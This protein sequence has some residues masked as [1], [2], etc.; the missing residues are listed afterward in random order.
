[1]RPD[2]IH[3][4][5]AQRRSA[6]GPTGSTHTNV[7]RTCHVAKKRQHAAFPSLSMRVAK[8]NR[9]LQPNLSLFP[10]TFLR[11]GGNQLLSSQAGKWSGNSATKGGSGSLECRGAAPPPR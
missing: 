1:M 7:K 6:T 9:H 5:H 11:N 10:D 3:I 4:A 8:L 2:Y